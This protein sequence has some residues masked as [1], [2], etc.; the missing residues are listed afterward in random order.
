MIRK[1]LKKN[2]I[3]FNL[4]FFIGVFQRFRIGN[5]QLDQLFL[6]STLDFGPSLKKT[7]FEVYNRTKM[8]KQKRC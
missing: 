8:H 7:N 4:D 3:I 6:V 5:F 1:S 2:L